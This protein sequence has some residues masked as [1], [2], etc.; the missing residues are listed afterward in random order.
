MTR[1]FPPGFTTANELPLTSPST[2]SAKRFASARQSRA[3][4]ASNAEGPGV[5]SNDLRKFRDSGVI[6][7]VGWERG[8]GR[9]T[10][11]RCLAPAGAEIQLQEFGALDRVGPVGWNGDEAQRRV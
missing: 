3:G 1:G 7:A 8:K 9:G 2:R 5:S 11:V 4:A 6:F 10:E